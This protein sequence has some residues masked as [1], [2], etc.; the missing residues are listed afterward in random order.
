MIM[1]CCM[2]F[3][4]SKMY[5]NELVDEYYNW[6]ICFILGNGLPQKYILK[7]LKKL[8]TQGTSVMTKL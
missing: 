8:S 7:Y 5:V 3:N 4:F 1:A 6:P 2:R